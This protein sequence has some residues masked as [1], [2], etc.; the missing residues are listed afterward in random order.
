MADIKQVI[1]NPK[2]QGL[3]LEEKRKVLM[4]I[5]SG[6]AG[7]SQQEQMRAMS[8]MGIGVLPEE[9]P[10]SEAASAIYTPVL[11]G[12]GGV[13][14]AAL[15][16]PGIATT[17]AGGALGIAA[18]KAT[19]N[20]IDRTIG[21]K[22]PI[23]DA[24]EAAK[25]TAS[26]IR[27]GAMMEMGGRLTGGLLGK[28]TGGFVKGADFTSRK[29]YEIAKRYGVKMTPAEI[30][31]SPSLSL[32][33]SVLEKLPLSKGM[34]L[35]MRGEEGK[36]IDAAATRLMEKLG[37][38][39][40]PVESG[41]KIQ[42]SV[43]SMIQV[44]K[45]R[46]NASFERLAGMAPKDRAIPLNNLAAKAQEA[47]S[48]AQ[49][50]IEGTEDKELVKTL[51]N[52]TNPQSRLSFEGLKL[53]REQFNDVIKSQSS[54]PKE[55]RIFLMLKNAIDEDLSSWAAGSGGRIEKA[56]RV[57]NAR[58]GAVNELKNNPIIRRILD[59]ETPERIVD[60]VF[61]PGVAGSVTEIQLLKK[62]MKPE[63]YEQVQRAVVNRLFDSPGD[64]SP[65]ISL[66]K[67]LKRYNENTIEAAIG[68]EKLTDLKN[69]AQLT[70]RVAGRAVEKMAGNPGGTVQ[71]ILTFNQGKAVLT[72]PVSGAYTL[73]AAPTIA[74]AYLS[75]TGRRLITEGMEIPLESGRAIYLAG[76]LT[77]LMKDELGKD[78]VLKPVI[79]KKSKP[80]QFQS[81]R[82]KIRGK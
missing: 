1:T 76:A 25:E 64:V 7:L 29:I 45:N 19:A 78:P 68:A 11:M 12:V 28:A 24:K 6:F 40:T 21:I 54:S 59:T 49:K 43:E 58:H 36:Q 42:G 57:A 5:S 37:N 22:E 77:K 82:D 55:K 65:A 48:D 81:Y 79:I 75:E 44:M 34:I 66:M 56:Y 35:R 47:V 14:G 41:S 13:G 61:R 2:F 3:P 62:A 80:N 50:V 70:E 32:L 17:P 15:A 9:K 20:L 27:E 60:S 74:K 23:A 26:N 31:G 67:N 71:N 8:G 10:L 53:Q 39:D 4:S 16:S 51:L 33:E 72:D 38:A 18:G 30:T 73:F 63:R 52:F 46:R 69:F